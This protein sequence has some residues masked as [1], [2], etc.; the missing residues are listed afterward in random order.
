[1]YNTKHVCRYN[2]DE[3]FLETDNVNNAEKQLI[4][5]ILYK[6]DLLQIFNIIID[7]SEDE[8][9]FI[10]LYIDELYN[11]IKNCEPLKEC[12]KQASNLLLNEDEQK[13][14]YILYSY[15]YMY[16]THKCVSEYLEK[17]IIQNENIIKL[18]E[19]IK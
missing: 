10:T 6:D 17:G 14:L 11:K 5:H 13:G 18:K 8:I 3:I 7:I 2:T 1:M 9:S 4:S 15:D 16:L 19:L 12:M